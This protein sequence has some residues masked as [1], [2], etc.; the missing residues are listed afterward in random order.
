MIFNWYATLHDDYASPIVKGMNRTNPKERA[1]DRTLNDDELRQVWR[2]AEANG[3]F[4]AFI[5]VALLTG[6][7]REK[8]LAM[9]WE[10][11]KDGEW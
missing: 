4:G 6:Q 10:D 3:M 11:V 1:R 8:L 7:R 2:T 9:R 5:R